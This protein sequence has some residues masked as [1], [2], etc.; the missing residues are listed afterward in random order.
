MHNSNIISCSKLPPSQILSQSLQLL[1]TWKFSCFLS[2]LKT[3]LKPFNEIAD[4]FVDNLKTVAD[5]ETK[6]PMKT[7]FG[8]FTLEVISKVKHAVT[9]LFMCIHQWCIIRKIQYMM[10]CGG[11]QCRKIMCDMLMYSCVIIIISLCMQ[12][13]FGSDFTQQLS[14]KDERFNGNHSLTYLVDFS[15]KGLDMS[16]RYPGYQVKHSCVMRFTLL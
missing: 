5:G 1:F 16:L 12:V 13:A 14:E 11:K 9:V 15:F 10:I 7:R 8:E 4:K 3:L 6:V 2:Y